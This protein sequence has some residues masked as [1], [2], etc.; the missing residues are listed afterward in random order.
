MYGY[1]KLFT[2]YLHY[3][4]TYIYNLSQLFW[5]FEI[6]FSIEHLLVYNSGSPFG[7]GGVGGGGM[8]VK[9]A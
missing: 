6:V 8:S 3:Y 5:Y 2:I 1:Y 4:A 9:E 7:A